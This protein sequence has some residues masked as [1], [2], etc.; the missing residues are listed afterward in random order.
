METSTW[1]A[2]GVCIAGGVLL[3]RWLSVTREERGVTDVAELF[4]ELLSLMIFWR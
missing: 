4:F 3:I 1:V 2:I